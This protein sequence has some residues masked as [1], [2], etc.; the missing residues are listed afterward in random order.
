MQLVVITIMSIPSAIA[1]RWMAQNLVSSL[2]SSDTYIHQ[3]TKP[4]LAQIMARYLFS[5]KPLPEPMMA[6]CQLAVNFFIEI[7]TF[8]LKKLHLIMSS[9]NVG[10][11]LSRSQYVNV[12]VLEWQCFALKSYIYPE[13]LDYVCT[14]PWVEP[15]K[16]Y[17]WD[18]FGHWNCWRP[19]AS[20][21]KEVNPRLAK[22]PLKT[23]GRLAN[24]GLTSLVKEATG[25]RKH[26]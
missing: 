1:L 20:F 6:Y 25:G 24:R 8:T 10:A 23:N 18:W 7:K 21:T 22:R 5:T 16:S 15:L 11:I 3:Q 13:L 12:W 2:R 19:V 4:P 17:H 9:P 26:L 14:E